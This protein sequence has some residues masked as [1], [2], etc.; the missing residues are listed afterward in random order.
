MEAKRQT[1]TFGAL[2]A[3]LFSASALVT[4]VAAQPSGD[5]VIVVTLDGMR[6]QEIFG[7]AGP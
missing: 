3:G 1:L 7:G 4:T 6:W 2:I 5:R